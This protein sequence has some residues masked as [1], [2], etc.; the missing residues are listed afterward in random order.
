MAINKINNSGYPIEIP[1][2]KKTKTTESGKSSTADKVNISK[3]ARS[4]LEEQKVK[5]LEE[6]ERKLQEGYY[7]E[8]EVLEKIADKILKDLK[9]EAS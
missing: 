3:E 8:Y 4:L 5:K 2:L 6:I 7:D 1:K 9:N